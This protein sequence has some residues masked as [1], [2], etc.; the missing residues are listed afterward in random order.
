M[1]KLTK[2]FV[3]NEIQRPVSEVDGTGCGQRCPKLKSPQLAPGVYLNII[4]IFSKFASIFR[5]T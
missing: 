1:S 5:V 3:E 4:P 2:H